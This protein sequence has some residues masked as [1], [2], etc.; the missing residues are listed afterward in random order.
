VYW[1][2]AAVVIPDI[3]VGICW[4]DY[5]NKNGL[6]KSYGPRKK[7]EHN[8]PAY[9]PQEASNPQLPWARRMTWSLA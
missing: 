1:Q 2:R 6:D 4:G 8:F 7:Y 5:W 3:S 9:Y